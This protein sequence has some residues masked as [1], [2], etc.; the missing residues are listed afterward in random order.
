MSKVLIAPS[1]LAVWDKSGGDMDAVVAAAMAVEKAGAD[2]IHVDVMDGQYVPAFTFGPEI[3][4]ALKKKVK[5]PLDVHLMVEDPEQMIA[6]YVKAGADRIVFHPSA[7]H[8]V[9]GVFGDDREGRTGGR[10]GAGCGRRS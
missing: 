10:A 9:W 3:V 2:W 4:K 8:D 7:S 6:D 5:I 1:I